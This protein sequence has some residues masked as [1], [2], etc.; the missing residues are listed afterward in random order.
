MDFLQW[1]L[2]K[3]EVQFCI[4]YMVAFMVIGKMIYVFRLYG[5]QRCIEDFENLRWFS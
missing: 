2:F 4:T 3:S 5:F 1:W